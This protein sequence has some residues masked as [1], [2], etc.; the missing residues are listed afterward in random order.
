MS[1]QVSALG[2]RLP[3]SHAA[4]YTDLPPL[5]LSV[6][7]L[8]R[9]LP[10]P[11]PLP[12]APTPPSGPRAAYGRLA[13]SPEKRVDSGAGLCP[14]QPELGPIETHGAPSGQDV[15]GTRTHRDRLGCPPE[16]KPLNWTQPRPLEAGGGVLS[17]TG[18]GFGELELLDQGEPG[19]G[20]FQGGPWTGDGRTDQ[21]CAVGSAIVTPPLK[22]GP[23]GPQAHPAS[24]RGA[25]SGQGPAPGEARGRA[26]AGESQSGRRARQRL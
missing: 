11:P 17:G 7:R 21:I 14:L 20:R 26:G 12:L 13:G 9:R 5:W 4:L 19:L 16:E 3:A 22:A 24:Q 8:G 18:L 2:R 1:C 25:P 6:L 23:G 15:L 10:N